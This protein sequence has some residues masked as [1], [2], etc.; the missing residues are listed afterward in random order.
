[1]Q[2][3]STTHKECPT[4][5]TATFTTNKF[6]YVIL[7]YFDVAKMGIDAFQNDCLHARDDQS[8][9]SIQCHIAITQ[10]QGRFDLLIKVRAWSK[11]LQKQNMAKMMYIPASAIFKQNCDYIS[12][13][14]QVANLD[15]VKEARFS[16]AVN[17]VLGN[18]FQFDDDSIQMGCSSKS[19]S[20]GTAL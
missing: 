12:V 1:M 7:T 4:S 8:G 14:K 2:L 13:N 5:S 19:Y 3:S 11:I 17:F 15:E 6:T 9:W 10:H 18:C 16:V 20:N